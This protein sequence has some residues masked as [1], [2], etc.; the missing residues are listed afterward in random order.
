M[1]L[2]EHTK[3]EGG[4]YPWLIL[5]IIIYIGIKFHKKFSLKL[6]IRKLLSCQLGVFLLPFYRLP[7]LFIINLIEV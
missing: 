5:N 3:S 6:V 1:L 2:Y 4:S 7:T